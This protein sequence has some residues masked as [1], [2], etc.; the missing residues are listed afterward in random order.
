MTET[1]VL[2]LDGLPMRAPLPEPELPALQ[3]IGPRM[4]LDTPPGA[5][6]RYR[7]PD[8]GVSADLELGRE[9]AV[10]R[11]EIGSWCSWVHLVDVP[12]NGFNTMHF[13]NVGEQP[14]PA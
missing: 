14:L 1:L 11:V 8:R 12:G 9:Y 10:R 4:S 3:F 5:K 13:D 2:M 7:Y 6:V